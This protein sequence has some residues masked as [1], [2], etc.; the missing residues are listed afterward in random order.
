MPDGSATGSLVPWGGIDDYILCLDRGARRLDPAEVVSYASRAA[1]AG[2]RVTILADQAGR[3]RIDVLVDA[4]F[5]FSRPTLVLV[6][7]PPFGTWPHVERDGALCIWPDGA[8]LAASPPGEIVDLALHRACT[9]IGSGAAGCG[10]ADF[11]DEML[12]YWN[13]ATHAGAPVIRSLLRPAGPSRAVFAGDVAGFPIVAE[14]EADWWRWAEHLTGRPSGRAPGFG[15]V[16]GKKEVAAVL[17]W[18]PKPLLPVEYPASAGELRTLLRRHAPDALGLLD[19]A[20]TDCP[21]RLLLLLGGDAGTGPCLVGVLLRRGSSPR[22]PS[23]RSP[24]R[25]ARGFRPGSVPADQ[26]AARWTGGAR[27]ERAKVE[28]VD[29]PWVHGRGRDPRAEDLRV[30]TVAILG[31]GSI[32][33]TIAVRLAEAGVGALVL[34]DPGVHQSANVGRH[35]L[36]ANAILHGKPEALAEL[37]KRKY[38]HVLSVGAFGESWQQVRAARPGIIEGCDLIVSAI[39]DWA[40]EGSLDSW[41]TS[42]PGLPPIMYAWAEPRARAGHAVLITRDGAS[43][44]CGFEPDGTPRF[45]VTEWPDGETVLTEAA[46]GGSFSPYGPVELAYITAMASELALDALTGA[47]S[48]TAHRIWAGRSQGLEA[49][50]GRWSEE[51]ISFAPGRENGGMVVDRDWGDRP[52]LDHTSDGP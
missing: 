7:R 23:G 40:D 18:L 34:I 22:L 2:W 3:R 28:R 33:S 9:L 30:R 25:D 35:E 49:A 5:P 46:C 21:N 44:R 47:V 4:S 12:S 45:R 13:P 15:S 37:I 29:H 17:A 51:W 20:V 8:R 36:G 24:D 26:A 10:T 32:G 38:P 41:H 43:L 27:L 31:C 6:D 1:V 39:G 19:A 52:R 48:C 14:T 16:R 11:R 50:G 42:A